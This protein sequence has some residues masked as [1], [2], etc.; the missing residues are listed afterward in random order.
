MITLTGKYTNAAIMIDNVEEQC[1]SQIVQFLNHPAFTNNVAIMPDTHAGK[2]SVIGF[3]MPLPDKV[4][5]NTIGSDISCGMLSFK[6]PPHMSIDDAGCITGVNNEGIKTLMTRETLDTAI[7][8]YIPFGKETYSVVCYNM[9]KD[10]PWKRANELNRSF[11]MAFNRLF[12]ETMQLTEYSYKWFE[13]KCEQIDMNV[14]R[15][16][17]S[18]GTLGGGKLIASSPR[19]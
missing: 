15:A 18:I 17:C 9:V 6:L 5:P 1:I 2:G 13:K 4:I 11:V 7:R 16:I 12:N 19:G 14:R 3:T 10:F 8:S